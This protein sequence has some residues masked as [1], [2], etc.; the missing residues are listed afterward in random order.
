MYW[1]AV[2]AG[3]LVMTFYEKRGHW[4]F[5]KAKG[6][7]ARAVSDSESG[8]PHKDGVIVGAYEK[9]KEPSTSGSDA[10][11]VSE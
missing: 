11:E 2:I 5:M 9:S 1:V 7:V 4:P 3:F 10:H 8:S 6:G